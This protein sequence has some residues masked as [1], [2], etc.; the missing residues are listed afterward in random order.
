MYNLSGLLCGV[1]DL[2][3]GSPCL[4]PDLPVTSPNNFLEVT[5]AKSYKRVNLISKLNKF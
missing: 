1:S 5:N 4:N 2:V 3:S